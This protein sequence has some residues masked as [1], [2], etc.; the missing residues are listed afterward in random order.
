[1]GSVLDDGSSLAEEEI[2]EDDEVSKAQA[3]SALY[4][5]KYG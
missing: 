2:V 1:V 4:S 5:G 3:I